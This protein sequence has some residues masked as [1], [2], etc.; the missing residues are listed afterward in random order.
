MESSELH[1]NE[2][3][4]GG[5]EARVGN[6]RPTGYPHANSCATGDSGGLHVASQ[7]VGGRIPASFPPFFQREGGSQTGQHHKEETAE[8]P[9]Q[10]QSMSLWALTAF[11]ARRSSSVV[12]PSRR[13][14]HIHP[15]PNKKLFLMKEDMAKEEH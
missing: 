13:A 15:Y 3:P 11:P 8:A 6:T 9:V 10:P 7:L 2:T 4:R 12:S 5:K 14:F 1:T